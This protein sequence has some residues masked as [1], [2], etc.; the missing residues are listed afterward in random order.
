M[1]G[2]TVIGNILVCLSV[3]LVRKLRH[4]SNYLLVSFLSFIFS[5]DPSVYS[6]RVVMFI[7]QFSLSFCLVL[8]SRY[9][10]FF[11]KIQSQMDMYSVVSFLSLPPLRQFSLLF[12]H[13]LTTLT[14]Y[15]HVPCILLRPYFCEK[16]LFKF[17]IP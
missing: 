12:L 16:L 8:Q 1:I 5:S 10:L 2:A 13:D 14:L 9:L 7:L 17:T 15:R 3:I 4:P 6:Y 11:E